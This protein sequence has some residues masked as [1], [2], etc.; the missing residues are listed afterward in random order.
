M[1]KKRMPAIADRAV[2][3]MGESNER[4]SWSKVGYCGR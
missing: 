4:T 2:P 3:G 1:P